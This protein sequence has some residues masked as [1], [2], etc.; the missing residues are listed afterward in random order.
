MVLTVPGAL[1]DGLPPV[2]AAQSPELSLQ[3]LQ[4]LLVLRAGIPLF[5]QLLPEGLCRRK[6][7]RKVKYTVKAEVCPAGTTVSGV[8]SC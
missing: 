3:C 1:A 5:P 8:G 4:F 2:R 7:P 6:D